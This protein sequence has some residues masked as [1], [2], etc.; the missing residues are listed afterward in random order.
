MKPADADLIRHAWPIN[1][2]LEFRGIET[3]KD[4]TGWRSQCPIHRGENKTAF[5]VQQDGLRWHCFRCSAGGDIIQLVRA[6]DGLDFLGA[7]AVLGGVSRGKPA[8]TRPSL[9]KPPLRQLQR[10]EELLPELDRGKHLEMEAIWRR[11]A[12]DDHLIASLAASRGWDADTVAALAWP[13]STS[14]HG[15]LGWA[16]CQGTDNGWICF[17]FPR[18]VKARHLFRDSSAPG[19]WRWHQPDGGKVV[20]WRWEKWPWNGRELW[21]EDRLKT[22]PV[23]R[24]SCFLTEGEPDAISAIDD[25]MED[26]FRAVMAIPSATI[27]AGLRC[28]LPDILRGKAIAFAADADAAGTTAVTTLTGI[29]RNSARSLRIV[30]LP[31]PV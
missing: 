17:L 26:T 10:Q 3:R 16:E 29:L 1:K 4:A 14:P 31:Q 23:A 15:C 13:T 12:E 20:R 2:W 5:M 11:L 24:D 9:R 25:F 22:S 7:C 28:R 6:V 30:N 18:A 19:G 8:T 21:R 27:G